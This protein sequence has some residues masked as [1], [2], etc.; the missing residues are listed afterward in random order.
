MTKK[1]D[2]NKMVE[3]LSEPCGCTVYS[4]ANGNGYKLE[5]CEVHAHAQAMLSHLVALS[6]AMSADD[7][8]TDYIMDGVEELLDGLLDTGTSSNETYGYMLKLRAQQIAEAS[9]QN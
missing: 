2:T 4:M 9:K 1:K 7:E 3:V 5:Y 8:P 6:D